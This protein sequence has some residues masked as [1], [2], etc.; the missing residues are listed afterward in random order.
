MD[1]LTSENYL[2]TKAKTATDPC[3]AKAWILTAKKLFPENFG[4]QVN[5]QF[6]IN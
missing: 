3:T 1:V 2:I 5:T 6:S 4:V